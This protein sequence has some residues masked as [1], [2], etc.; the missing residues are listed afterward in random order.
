MERKSILLV[1]DDSSLGLTLKDRLEKDGLSVRLAVN[2][3]E[4][5]EHLKSHLDLI[6]LDVGLPDGSG[7]DFAKE[8]RAQVSTPFLFVTAQSDAES[9]LQGYETGAEEFIPKPFHL[10]EFLMRVH[11][12]LSN[13]AALQKIQ[14][15]GRDFIDFDSFR[16][17]IDDHPEVL[18]HKE[19]MVLK[20]LIESTPKVVSRD[21]LLNRFWGEE[22]FPTQRTVDNVIVKLRSVLGDKYNKSI[23]SVRGVGYQWGSHQ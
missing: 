22:K 5:R 13:H 18:T 17:V 19:A 2:L 8:V 7:F 23:L 9:R 6:I 4:A 21:E 20:H 16:I 15:S 14:L 11:H 12:V 3:A 1:E 10:K